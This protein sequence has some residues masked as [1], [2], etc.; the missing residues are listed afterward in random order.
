MDVRTRA[1]T[2]GG[3]ELSSLRTEGRANSSYGLSSRGRTGDFLDPKCCSWPGTL[4]EPKTGQRP[5]AVKPSPI[6][7]TFYMYA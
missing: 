1:T 5:D 4:L 2:N 7:C 6:P 3:V